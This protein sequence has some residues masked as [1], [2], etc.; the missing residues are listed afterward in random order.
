MVYEKTV[1]SLKNHWLST[2]DKDLA[3]CCARKIKSQERDA[4]HAKFESF[5][6]KKLLLTIKASCAIH[7]QKES[8][9][10]ILEA[11]QQSRCVCFGEIIGSLKCI[12]L[13]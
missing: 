8:I 4:L 7:W 1:L 3:E 9:K 11:V 12:F 2:L 13:F 10:K 5:P 6:H